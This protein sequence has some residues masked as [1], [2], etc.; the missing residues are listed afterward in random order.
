VL[1]LPHRPHR[2]D[3]PEI[4]FEPPVAA[5]AAPA[6]TVAEGRHERRVTLDL[7]TG[8]AV[9]VTNGEGGLFGEGVR[10]FTDIDT[11]VGHDLKREL[12]IDAGDPLSATYRL[13]QTYRLGRAGWDIEI[14]TRTAMRATAEHFH[15]AGEVEAFENGVRVRDRRFEETIAR[16]LV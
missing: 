16:D 12:V 10:R 9:Y 5:M 14:R 11:Q 15:L 7:L 3:E 2:P 1:T 8:H 6:E 13:T 4:R